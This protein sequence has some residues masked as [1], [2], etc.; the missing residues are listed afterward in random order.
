MIFCWRSR[1]TNFPQ[2]E[3]EAEE[4]E[5][6]GGADKP[7]PACTERGS[8][9]VKMMGRMTRTEIG[10]PDYKTVIALLSTLYIT[11]RSVECYISHKVNTVVEDCLITRLKLELEGGTSFIERFLQRLFWL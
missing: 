5:E 1:R 3:E 4:E 2:E 9:Q 8:S 10:L 11:T 6:D 7:G